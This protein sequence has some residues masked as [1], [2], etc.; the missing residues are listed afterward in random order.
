MSVW[1]GVKEITH[2]AKI[3]YSVT[4]FM[5]FIDCHFQFI[6]RD[7]ESFSHAE[8]L[9]WCSL[10][11]LAYSM[12]LVKA[13]LQVPESVPLCSCVTREISGLHNPPLLMS[14]QERSKTS[15]PRGHKFSIY[16]FPPCFTQSRNNALVSSDISF[17]TGIVFSNTTLLLIW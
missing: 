15:V 13:V 5:Q 14:L 2:R 8:D 12:N 7:T 3:C 10:K 6:S 16:S 17:P 9:T 4:S 1:L 11:G